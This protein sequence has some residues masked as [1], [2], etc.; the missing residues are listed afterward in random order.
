MKLILQAEILKDHDYASFSE[1][2]LEK[3]SRGAVIL[4]KG[5]V[6]AGKTTFVSTVCKVF[7][8]EFTQSPTYAIHNHYENF[9]VSID[10]F[11]LYR[12][13]SEDE[14]Q[15]S[16]FYDLLAAHADYKFIEWSEKINAADLDYSRPVYELVITVNEDQSRT[17]K[18]FRL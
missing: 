2:F 17:C 15:A 10:H 9:N 13:D 16:G 1:L 6:G 11:D 8:L 5:S 3:I 12:L 18:L 7:G 14:I 4:M